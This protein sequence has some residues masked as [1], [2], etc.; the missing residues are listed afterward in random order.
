[1]KDEKKVAELIT[2]LKAEVETPYELAAV[3]RLEK[4]LIE[5]APEVE[6]FDQKHKKFNGMKFYKDNKNGYYYCLLGLHQ[7]M[8]I[9]HFGEIREGYSIHHKDCKKENNSIFNLQALDRDDHAQIHGK[10]SAL[11]T[12]KCVVCGKEYKAKERGTNLTCSS[13]CRARKNSKG[14]VDVKEERICIIC[15]KKFKS[16]KYRDTK[17]CS[18]HCGNIYAWQNRRA[19][20]GEKIM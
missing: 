16:R 1:M 15:G 8:W 10:L 11:K 5:G 18:Q 14:F 9:H 12:F 13:A 20:E 2:A 6:D 4:E 7:A 19:K 3:E 17:T